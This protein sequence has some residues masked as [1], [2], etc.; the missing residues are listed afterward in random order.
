MSDV[1]CSKCKC[2]THS[3]IDDSITG[4]PICIDCY[5]DEYNK[6]KNKHEDKK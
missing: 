5:I 2:I 3:S 4:K 1:I 6:K